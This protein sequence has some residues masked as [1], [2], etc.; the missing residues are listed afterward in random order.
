MISNGFSLNPKRLYRHPAAIVKMRGV[1]ASVLHEGRGIESEAVASLS[2]PLPERGQS[3]HHCSG[4][5]K[6][7]GRRD[8][9][10]DSHRRRWQSRAASQVLQRVKGNAVTKKVSSEAFSL[11]RTNLKKKKTNES[12]QH[13]KTGLFISKLVYTM[14]LLQ[15][16]DYIFT[17]KYNSESKLV[18]T[19]NQNKQFLE[20]K[21][22]QPSASTALS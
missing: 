8:G 6:R 20:S 11:Q 17:N 9:V 15:T 13:C 18:G 2:V 7:N 19:T 14:N 22:Q 1:G 4:L 12:G 16:N 21:P 3:R 10:D 5:V